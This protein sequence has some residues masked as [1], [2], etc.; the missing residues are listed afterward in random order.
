MPRN[1][2]VNISA[3]VGN[4][5]GGAAFVK[6]LQR[7]LRAAPLTIDIKISRTASQ[8]INGLTARLNTY[9]KA[10]AD[11]AA[12]TNTLAQAVSNLSNIMSTFSVNANQGAAALRQFNSSAK[13]SSSASK[14]IQV[15]SNRFELLGD[16]IAL[17]AKRFGAFMLAARPLIALSRA[18][19]EAVSEAVQFQDQMV[20]LSQ[21]TGGKT[22]RDV[23]AVSKQIMSLSATLGVS[24]KDL[25][26]IADT[27]LQ[28]GLKANETKIA[29]ESLAK[30]AL[31][32]TFDS[33]EQA[34]E[35]LIAMMG[36]FNIPAEQFSKRLSQINT[37]SAKYAA[38]SSDYITAIRKAGA[39]FAGA[40]GNIEEL[41]A[42]FTAV[43]DSSRESADTIA[44]SFRTIFA[45]LQRPGTVNFL[46]QLGIQL[47]DV[48]GNFV[49]PF[50]AVLN[51]A[52]KLSKIHP[53]SQLFAQVVE[54]IGGIRQV[55]KVQTLIQQT[56]KAREALSV[57]QKSGS[58]IDQDAEK[59]QQSLVV[60]LTK[61]N[62]T[63]KNLF[64]T[65]ATDKSFTSFAIS[66]TKLATS[67]VQAIEKLT[68][69]L[70]IIAGLGALTIGS[71]VASFA[72]G[73]TKRIL[74][75]A[76]GGA[77]GGTGNKDSE[78][79]M[80]MPGEFVLNKRA[81][82]AIGVENLH[83][84]NEGQVSHYAK[85]TPR[86]KPKVY[87]NFKDFT[88]G[89]VDEMKLTQ[90][91]KR[92][93]A[94]S[95]GA[96][97]NP[98][99]PFGVGG[100]TYVTGAQAAQGY[101]DSNVL[102][103]QL[104]VAREQNKVIEEET[105]IRDK[106]TKSTKMSTDAMKARRKEEEN[107]LRGIRDG[108][109]QFTQPSAR[110]PDSWYSNASY[111]KMRSSLNNP[112]RALVPVGAAYTS[113]TRGTT[114]P[115]YEPTPSN[116]SRY[117]YRMGQSGQKLLG[118][119]LSVKV[120]GVTNYGPHSNAIPG[121][122]PYAQ[123]TTY[124][125]PGSHFNSYSTPASMGNFYRRARVAGR[126]TRQFFN[127]NA[128][129]IGVGAGLAGLAVQS[130]FPDSAS[131]QSPVG[132]AFSNGLFLGGGAL[133]LTS[134]P[135]LA[136]AA[137]IGGAYHGYSQASMFNRN[138]EADRRLAGLTVGGSVKDLSTVK[139]F[140]VDDLAR[141][142]AEGV[143][144][145]SVAS[146]YVRH[147]LSFA[148][149]S[150]QISIIRDLQK[151]G[152]RTRG[153][154]LLELQPKFETEAAKIE[155][156]IK[157]HAARGGSF[158]TLSQVVDM[159]N[160]GLV[161]GAA[162]T[163]NVE[164]PLADLKAFGNDEMKKLF[165][166]SKPLGDLNKAILELAQQIDNDT[167][168]FEDLADSIM[169]AADKTDIFVNSSKV[170]GGGLG[171]VNVGGAG[172]RLGLAANGNLR[173]A[174]AQKALMS[175][176]GVFG[177]TG[178]KLAGQL[179][180]TDIAQGILGNL[181]SG[182]LQGVSDTEGIGSV[183]DNI[184]KDFTTQFEKAA[185]H[186]IDGTLLKIIEN[187]LDE[188]VANK[189]TTASFKNKALDPGF[190]KGLFRDIQPAN[191]ELRKRMLADT[192][193][194]ADNFASILEEVNS[195]INK[196]FDM[197]Q[198]GIGVTTNIE[199]TK[200]QF[201]QNDL[202]DPALLQKTFLTGQSGLLAGAGIKAGP[203]DA[204]AIIAGRDKL[205]GQVLAA[206]K[207]VEQSGPEERFKNIKNLK[208]LNT[209]LE[210]AEKAVSNLTD[211]MDELNKGPLER[212]NQIGQEKNARLGFG[213]K[214]LGG[215]PMDALRALQQN[216]AA[217]SVMARGNFNGLNSRQRQ[218]ALAG[219][220]DMSGMR[221]NG[222]LVDDIK[223]DLIKATLPGLIPKDLMEEEKEL[224][225]QVIDNLGVQAQAINGN[226]ASL[227]Q[228]TAALVN[229]SI[230]LQNVAQAL[231]NRPAGVPGGAPFAHGGRPKG[232]DTVP[233]MLT[234]GEFV[235]NRRAT[236]KFLP[237]LHKINANAINPEDVQYA[238]RGMR[239]PAMRDMN[240][241]TRRNLLR[242]GIIDEKGKRLP[243]RSNL[244]RTP[245]T[246]IN[247]R[248][249]RNLQ[250]RGIPIE[251]F[252]GMGWAMGRGVPRFDKQSFPNS[253]FGR[254]ASRRVARR[255]RLGMRGYAEGGV[256]GYADGGEVGGG[257]SVSA[258]WIGQFVAAT[259]TLAAAISSIPSE[260]SLTGSYTVH[261]IHNG[262]TVSQEI[263]PMVQKM[264]DDA[265][266]TVS[267]NYRGMQSQD[268]E[269]FRSLDSGLS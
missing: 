38:E 177:P 130:A 207:A 14:H 8:G 37:L 48:K 245:F 62:E 210:H 191:D 249:F 264:I 186:K 261:I 53:Q 29:L 181:F 149:K 269:V 76:G 54:E 168:A 215:G 218:M 61:L 118:A 194:F 160:A 107:L 49:G 41:L 147:P 163:G 85:G 109:I 252:G 234:P 79:A 239:L 74:S 144:P 139:K 173:N 120:T 203:L 116:V 20:R 187:Q 23:A 170:L 106:A 228:N 82:K 39:S 2:Q 136:G 66:L 257:G 51:I 129:R 73:F 70:P 128:S 111:Q 238:Q 126:S 98:P 214:L 9:S 161:F 229:N 253:R 230:E 121:G 226:I 140:A 222:K 89:F 110:N 33:I 206:Q 217:Q 188:S 208:D 43:R 202:V 132:N 58:S 220:N 209:A 176:L 157:Q 195:N 95:L 57:A 167:Q 80:L 174:D 250:R 17:S 145:F 153:N 81:V 175:E 18:F 178:K 137:A 267:K 212:L 196:R 180:D 162:R 101:G 227:D 108:N 26:S 244:I 242:R 114:V 205:R 31:A 10:A 199:L 15:F 155:A 45:R 117:A 28:A 69:L 172:T 224:Q 78:P 105:K 225:K 3:K 248:T 262:L 30:V 165:N 211:N 104:S 87:S 189:D 119:P 200:R 102:S 75:F 36:Q 152:D 190:A 235:I 243:G 133:S 255:Q 63:F 258:P 6:S 192:K 254:A 40:G 103:D 65:I 256:V 1:L 260:I 83:R 113:T 179:V 21:I 27:L 94:K 42:L 55:N 171:Q 34:G 204:N 213:E 68:P 32:P 184:M 247:P 46:E 197:V 13:Q 141:A 7:Q 22:I 125:G 115:G 223:N 77:V 90:D 16:R 231:M 96:T 11:A 44:T 93:L 169:I 237:L 52:E 183:V 240:P 84:F 241:R 91:Q 60:S 148:S 92:R 233:A 246:N 268:G 232:T 47:R 156:A 71:K 100:K 86:R 146:A 135:Y 134:N 198:K 164:A 112:G 88:K 236:E 185:G 12:R 263:M 131:Y 182:K 265:I 19:D 166:L 266:G 97:S 142:S 122:W 143:T 259:Q 5:Q 158:D 251:Q 201:A 159:K 24:S 219:L 221:I 216:M 193:R 123:P 150:G 124:P 50:Q 56:A 99:R 67:A 154:R 59:R 127:R 25:T 64:K 151:A 138:R 72:G 4:V 35:G